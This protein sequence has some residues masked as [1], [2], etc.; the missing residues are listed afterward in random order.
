MKLRYIILLIVVYAGSCRQADE[1]SGV[2]WVNNEKSI[3]ASLINAQPGDTI[4]LDSGYYWFTKGMVLEGK[5]NL[6][7]KGAGM[8]KTYLSFKGQTSGSAGLKISNCKNI[9]LIGFHI[10]DAK[11]DN[12]KVSETDGIFFKGLRTYWTNGA[13]STNGA[14]GLYPV[15]CKN[16]LIEDCVAARASDAGIYVGQSDTVIIR[17]N[18]VYEN[19]AGIESENSN[20]VDIYDN[21]VF[22]NT[23]GI[24]IF[25]LPG[26]TQYGSQT[27]IFNNMVEGNNHRNFAPA[28]NIVS[29]V[30]PGTGI[31]LL[32]TRDAEIFDNEIVHNRTVGTAITSYELI[33]AMEIEETGSGEGSLELHNANYS[34]DTLYNPFPDGVYI[35]S[36]FYKSKHWFPSLRNDFGKLLFRY[37]PFKS[38]HILWD[39]FTDPDRSEESPILCIEQET[40]INFA[41][42]NVPEDLKNMEKTTENYRCSGQKLQQVKLSRYGVVV[43]DKEDNLSQENI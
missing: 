7:I 8:D 2:D 6:V 31:M 12:I 33:L 18:V 5:E 13:K 25:D 30:P 26:L 11:G 27:R 41:N 40:D 14:Y 3:Q 38:I 9:E 17:R 34:L 10:E 4:V 37:F 42:I 16:V 28:G 1:R 32:S 29:S 21:K 24:L 36:N 43:D 22:N 15:L 23:G 39:G 20:I 19:V 35:H